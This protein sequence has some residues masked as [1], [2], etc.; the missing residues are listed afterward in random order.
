MIQCDADRFEN[1]KEQ[2][3]SPAWESYGDWHVSHVPEGE[4][5]AKPDGFEEMLTLSQSLSESFPHV[6]VDWY[7]IEG[8]PFF[9]ELTFYT[10]GGFD[11]FHSKEDKLRDPLDRYLGDCLVLPEQA[12]TLYV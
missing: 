9:G 12:R 6:R 10:G 3:F 4:L 11:P 8:K 1:H 5:L 7:C 2:F